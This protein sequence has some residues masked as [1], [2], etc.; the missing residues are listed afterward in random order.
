MRQNQRNGNGSCRSCLVA[1]KLGNAR[2]SKTEKGKLI[3]EEIDSVCM[4]V[5]SNDCTAEESLFLGTSALR[6]R[7][8]LSYM[9]QQYSFYSFIFC[10][11]FFFY[12]VLIIHYFYLHL[13]YIGICKIQVQMFLGILIWIFLEKCNACYMLGKYFA[14]P[15]YEI[16]IFVLLCIIRKY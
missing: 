10:F 11:F 8:R 16:Q 14:L 2:K 12:H 13:Q 9:E 15:D 7:L 5:D 4:A 6:L 1:E 3:S